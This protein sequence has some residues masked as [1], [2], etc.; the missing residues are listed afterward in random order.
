MRVLLTGANGFLGKRVAKDL[1]K[2]GHELLLLVRNA[3]KLDRFMK[4]IICDQQKANIQ[5]IEGYITSGNL[6]LTEEKIQ[7]LE[8]KIDAIYHMAALLSFDEKDEALTYEVNV[9][10]TK[11]VLNFAV[12]VQCEKFLYVST[13]YTIGKETEGAEALYSPNREF[14]NSYER[15]KCEAEHLVVSY[16]NQ[17]S[18]AILRPAIIIGDSVT[19]QA[20]T[21][22]GLYGIL[23][24]LNV[25]K[26]KINRKPELQTLPFR[27]I[28][29]C[30]VASNIVPVDYVSSV[31]VAA[32]QYCENRDI[33]NITNPNPPKQDAVVQLVKGYME[34]PNL[35]IVHPDCEHQLR[36]D[37]REFNKPLSV[38]SNYLGRNI[39][40]PCEKTAYVLRQ[41]NKPVLDMNEE[42]LEN[43]IKGFIEKK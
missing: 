33:L 28:M 7:S 11:H 22:F 6:G 8:G 12:R 41:A 43:I 9:M 1:L 17:I 21:S 18:V 35:G 30:E 39:Y 2:E 42:M 25:L 3:K 27:L 5:I 23:K 19:G 26:R 20:E 31:L 24:S 34:L 15:T 36:D 38:F 10:G 29:D 13:A 40:F 16:S 4:D 37:E 14:V 32:L